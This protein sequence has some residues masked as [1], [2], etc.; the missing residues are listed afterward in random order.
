MDQGIIILM[1]VLAAAIAPPSFA[2]FLRAQSG[3][4]INY[5]WNPAYVPTIQYTR[6]AYR[7]DSVTSAGLST[8]TSYTSQTNVLNHMRIFTNASVR[9]DIRPRVEW[10]WMSID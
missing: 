10:K 1:I 2:T 9:L 7:V 5:Q 4:H 6:W 8:I 3:Q